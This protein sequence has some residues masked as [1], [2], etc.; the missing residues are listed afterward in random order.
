MAVKIISEGT[1]KRTVYRAECT[2]CGCVYEYNNEDVVEEEFGYV[3]TYHT[4][5]PQCH[6]K[7]KHGKDPDFSKL[8]SMATVRI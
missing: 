4:H 5:C 7:V 1:K 2:E 6:N 8:H 3:D